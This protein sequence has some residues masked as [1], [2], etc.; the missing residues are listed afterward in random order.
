MP[1]DHRHGQSVQCVSLPL[2]IVQ[3]QADETHDTS[4]SSLVK[5]HVGERLNV[6]PSG[7]GSV[8][9]ADAGVI[10]LDVLEGVVV[11]G[12]LGGGQDGEEEGR[13]EEGEE[14]GE[15]HGGW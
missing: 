2:A 1:R 11:G 15:L 14:L 6:A 7:R 13:G 9:V 12:A 4:R 10:G 5:L 3:R 8:G